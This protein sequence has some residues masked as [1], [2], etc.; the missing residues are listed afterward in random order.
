[1]EVKIVSKKRKQTR[2][3]GHY[4]VKWAGS[5]AYY[6]ASEIWRMGS[7]QDGT[8]WKLIGD[9]RIYYDTDFIE[10]NENRIPFSKGPLFA[11]L[12]YW[13]ATI[14]NIFALL[15]YVHYYLTHK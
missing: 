9:E 1:M 7:Y 10:I 2:Q 13:L 11:G 8:G 5:T 4:W 6:T 14:A 12:W 15:T 3:S